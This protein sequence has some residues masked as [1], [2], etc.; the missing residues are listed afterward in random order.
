MGY[1]DFDRDRVV[2]ILNRILEAE[3]AVAVAGRPQAD[4][5]VTA[6]GRNAWR[7]R[8]TCGDGPHAS[9]AGQE[10]D[11]RSPCGRVAQ[12][13]PANAAL[14]TPA[15]LR[16]LARHLR[17]GGVFALW[18]DDP[19]DAGFEAALAEV[20]AG[21]VSHVVTFDNPITGG[22]SSNTVY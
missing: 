6:R 20:F 8:A 21:P 18:S 5:S 10:G 12:L 16:R 1:D 19:P 14:Y 22:Q 7:R 2:A 15:G 13:D 3:L 11:F 9:V 4:R 17:D